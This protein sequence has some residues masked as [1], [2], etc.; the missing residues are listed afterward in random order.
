VTA[1][2]RVEPDIPVT[3]LALV[4]CCPRCRR[5]LRHEVERPTGYTL[6]CCDH[7]GH[8]ARV[9]PRLGASVPVLRPR[10]GRARDGLRRPRGWLQSRV[11]AALPTRARDALDPAALA[12]AL[13]AGV[14]KEAVRQACRRLVSSG[15][16]QGGSRAAARRGSYGVVSYWRKS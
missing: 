14:T 13:E 2:A 10:P 11:L 15:K 16:A 12:R 7:C 5:V 9:R 1:A 4:L 3:T 6:E 8:R